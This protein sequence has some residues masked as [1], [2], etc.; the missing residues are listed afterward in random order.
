MRWAGF[1]RL[2]FFFVSHSYRWVLITSRLCSLSGSGSM[3]S[4]FKPW[5]HS[6]HSRVFFYLRQRVVFVQAHIK[7]QQVTNFLIGLYQSNTL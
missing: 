3:E 7:L 5:R 2:N 1:I 6:L 4:V